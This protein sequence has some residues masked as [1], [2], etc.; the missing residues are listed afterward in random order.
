MPDISIGFY[1][2]GLYKYDLIKLYN[3]FIKWVLL[4]PY[5]IDKEPEVQR[6]SNLP[7]S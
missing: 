7:R 4:V 6:V 3:N 2:Y 1:K 5:F